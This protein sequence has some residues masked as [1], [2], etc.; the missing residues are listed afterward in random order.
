MP[1]SKKF[2]E[3][4]SNVKKEYTGKKVPFKYQ[5][6]YGKVYSEEEAKEIGFAIAAKRGWRK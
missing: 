5:K 6:K 3:L 1:H 2:T 4:L